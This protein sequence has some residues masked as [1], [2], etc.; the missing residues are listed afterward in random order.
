MRPTTPLGSWHEGEAKAAILGFVERVTD[1]GGAD[2]V[3]PPER[4]A[5]FD[6]DG[7]L[8]C[9]KPM[10]SEPGF[11]LRRLAEMADADE[12]LREKQPWKAASEQ[13]YHWL[14]E[15]ITKHYH[16]DDADVKVLMAGVLQAFA[17]M[18]VEDYAA[19]ADSFL[20]AGS[21]RRW[22]GAFT[23]AATFRWSSCCSTSMR[24]ASRTTSRPAATETSCGR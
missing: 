12:S 17:G 5:V 19:A 23:P 11:I 8:W 15:A 4:V 9:E 13:D 7:T 22:G 2:Y 18:S 21:T 6:N 10:P 20:R 14:G 16:G 24:T 3:A 1:E